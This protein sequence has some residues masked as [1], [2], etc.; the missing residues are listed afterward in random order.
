MAEFQYDWFKIF[1]VDDFE[2]LGLISKTYTYILQSLG[3]KDFLVTKGNLV[4]ITY[5]G[6]Y[7]P[8]SMNDINPF[9]FEDFAIYKNAD[10]DVFWG[11]KQAGQ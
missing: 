1:N 6:V 7:L 10:N 11:I 2:S 9:E 4:G 3:E 5:E 8:I